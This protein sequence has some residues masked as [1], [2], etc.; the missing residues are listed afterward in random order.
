MNRR[1]PPP[2]TH[3]F[4]LPTATGFL[5]N[6]AVEEETLEGQPEKEGSGRWTS[7][8]QKSQASTVE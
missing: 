8:S 3:D 7:L 1:H 5:S 4:T 6:D 2:T